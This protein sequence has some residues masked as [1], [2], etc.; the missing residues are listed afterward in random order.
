MKA[1]LLVCETTPANI[2]P[3]EAKS[4][5]GMFENISLKKQEFTDVT[6]LL[7]VIANVQKMAASIAITQSRVHSSPL[8]LSLYTIDV[9]PKQ[10]YP[11]P[12]LPQWK[13]YFQQA[14]KKI[15]SCVAME[16]VN[17]SLCFAG[18]IAQTGFWSCVL[19]LS[20]LIQ[21][22]CCCCTWSPL[23]S[24]PDNVPNIFFLLT[25]QDIKATFPNDVLCVV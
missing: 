1:Q 18:L 13:E 20:L 14:K 21:T 11:P 8:H 25:F 23:S 10:V 22:L 15:K 24:F 7:K 5:Q 9:K 2:K 12:A 6:N 4:L 17:I 3:E 16:T 19:S